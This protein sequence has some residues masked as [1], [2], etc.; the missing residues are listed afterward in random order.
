[1]FAAY[2]LIYQQK[3]R[4]SSK[5]STSLFELF[6]GWGLISVGSVSRGRSQEGSLIVCVRQS[7]TS[8]ILSK[9][10]RLA[11]AAINETSHALSRQNG[12]HRDQ[13]VQAMRTT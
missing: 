13:R 10:E 3:R 8:A 6:Q 9:S 11:E 2:C 4:L 5:S 1:M 12:A 7:L